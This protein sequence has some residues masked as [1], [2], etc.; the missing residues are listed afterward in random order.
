[1]NP[2][3][4]PGMNAGMNPGM[5]P[6]MNQAPP[7]PVDTRGIRKEMRGPTIDQNLFSGTPLMSNYPKPP[8]PV[9][10]NH[11]NNP[12]INDPINED[13]RFSIASSDSSL[14]SVS[15]KKIN[16]NNKRGKNTKSAGFELNIK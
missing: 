16:I 10:F 12:Y 8:V 13:D 5:F 1:M 7:K 6:G 9:E 15:V 14:S 2:G 4:N 3:M 11:N